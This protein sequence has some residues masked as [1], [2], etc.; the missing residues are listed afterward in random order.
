V[1]PGAPERAISPPSGTT[2]TRVPPT[3]TVLD[4]LRLLAGLAGAAA[5]GPRSFDPNRVLHDWMKDLTLR[6]RSPNLFLNLIAMRML[7][8]T[9]REVSRHILDAYPRRTGYTAGTPKRKGMSYLAPQALT[10]A[11]GEV[12]GRLR[13]FNER[14]LC[15]GRPHD[16]QRVFLA[17]VRRAFSVPVRSLEDISA[18]MGRA[19]L[20]IV[21]GEGV[22]PDSL[23]A[24]IR[25]LFGLVQSPVKRRLHGRRERQR[26]ELLYANFRRAW[27]TNGEGEHPTLLGIAQGAGGGESVETLLQQIPHWMFT[28]S[29]SGADLLGRGLAMVGSRPDILTRVRQEIA[30]AG[31]LD[32]PASID[33]LRYLE[34]CLLEAARLFPPVTRTFHRAASDDAVAGVRIPAGTEILQVFSLT[35]RDTTSDR[36]ADA[37]QPER[38]LMPAS[39]AEAAYP[40]LFLSGARRC[41]GRDLILFV[42]KAAAAQLLQDAGIVM[43]SADLAS[44][45]VPFT[46]PAK[47]LRFETVPQRPVS[48]TQEVPAPLR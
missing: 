17:Q 32:D 37:F 19:M 35:Q 38:W 29:G 18:G 13:P 3:S 48:G 12:W 42:C 16:Y 46:F 8:V 1:K 22:A 15:T 47:R 36:T 43:R 45:P 2:S 44:D 26:V 28:F 14:V 24:D 9:D 40:N 25:V 20:G 11:D 41:P 21:F 4:L 33:R 23:V 31:P 34:A 30:A 6:Y 5:R 10:I 7:L 39:R 27:Q